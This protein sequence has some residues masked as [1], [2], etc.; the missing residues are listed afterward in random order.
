MKNNKQNHSFNTC[1]PQVMKQDPLAKS[2]FK[3]DL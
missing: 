3:S 2:A 1:S